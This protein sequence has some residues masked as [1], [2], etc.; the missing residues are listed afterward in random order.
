MPSPLSLVTQ[1]TLSTRGAASLSEVE[2]VPVLSALITPRGLLHRNLR[3]SMMQQLLRRL[4]FDVP[5][6]TEYAM[7][8]L[9]VSHGP[10][11]GS[12]PS[13]VRWDGADG[14]VLYRAGTSECI[15]GC[16]VGERVVVL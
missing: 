3:P 13:W 16:C 4:V 1:S 10:T 2:C 5:M 8:A 14:G 6:L 7:M 9:R 12:P 15:M 11:L